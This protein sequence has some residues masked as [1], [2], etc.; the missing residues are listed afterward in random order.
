MKKLSYAIVALIGLLISYNLNIFQTE[1]VQATELGPP[2]LPK[3]ENN[4]KLD[5]NLE[6][7]K[8]SIESNQLFTKVDANVSHPTKIVEKVVVKYK[9]KIVYET[10]T[11]YKKIFLDYPLPKSK[12]NI[13]CIELPKRIEK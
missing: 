9:E 13:P 4:F 11:E 10:K 5:L 3:I 12:L 8:A 7:G 6:T 1:K 2:S